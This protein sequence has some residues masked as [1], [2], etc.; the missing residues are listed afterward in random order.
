MNID[1][2]YGI[3]LGLVALGLLLSP[4]ASCGAA[5]KV[6]L[7][8]GSDTAVWNVAN[9]VDV[10]VY[11]GRFSL[12]LYT[13]PQNNAARVMDPAFRSRFSD[14]Y[15]KPL[16]LTWWMLVGSVYRV[17]A[18]NDVP[19][20]NLMS[21]Y[22]M[23]KYYGDAMRHLG[24]EVALHYHTFF[25]SDYN[26]DG[27]YYWNQSRTFAECRE[28]FD[29]TLAQGLVEEEFFPAS[30]RSGWHFMDNEWQQRL[31][32]LIPFSLHDASP[33]VL[34]D[35]TEPL[36]NVYDWSIAPTAFVPFHPSPTNYQIAGTGPG[37]N[38]RSV[39]V[40]NLTQT[41]MN[42][43]FAAAAAGTDQVACLWVHLP[44]SDFLTNLLRVDTLAHVAA[45]KH[46]TVS[47]RYCTAVEAMQLWMGTADQTPPR[48]EVSEETHGE[49]VTLHVRVD[50]PIFQPEPFVALKDASGQI[51]ILPCIP[52]GTNAWRVAVPG[53]RSQLAKIGVAVTDPAGNLAKQFLRYLPDDLYLD[54]L[55]SP[56][57][58]LQ[59]NWT[60]TTNA[61]WGID[62][63][64]ALLT[65]N[66]TARVRW[67][68]P[69]TRAGAY[70]LLVQAP[71][72]SNAAPHLVFQVY[73]GTSAV[74]TVSLPQAL[75]SKEWV[76]LATPFLDP[77]REN[78]L[79]MSVSG[80]GQP[81]TVVV[82]DVVKVS[83]VPFTAPTLTQLQ[84]TGA[85]FSLS[86]LTQD[87]LIYVLESADSLRRSD[88]SVRQTQAGDGTTLTFTDSPAAVRSRFY[89][90][91]VE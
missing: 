40:P 78:R 58:E 11:R 84:L 60:S 17:A 28:D 85:T 13:Q 43:M 77:A 27:K 31:N 8:V 12:D 26:Q 65:E 10:G 88:W 44:E 15:G 25:W 86:A 42:Q 14:S 74:R 72:V 3:R 38:V 36:G 53:P 70:Q 76:Y 6:Y 4:Y 91:R 21:L 52:D 2:A 55:D 69:I 59:G 50:E 71:V 32:A 83:A 68:L 34:R 22:L 37:W 39:K 18:N 90:L 1:R 66:D 46:A 49:E 62:A 64:Q 67:T 35:T 16:R 73:S 89:R 87:G 29:F 7:V 56:Y 57:A 24:D 81:N 54:N 33:I 30:F 63:R 5:G 9:G 23:Q 20:P 75:P 80:A 45:S 61:A 48:L 51:S 47:F 82:A 41:A 19:V 79:E